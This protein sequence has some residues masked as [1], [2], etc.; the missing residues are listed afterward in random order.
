MSNGATALTK[1]KSADRRNEPGIAPKHRKE[2]P[3]SWAQLAGAGLNF[4]G[5]LGTAKSKKALGDFRSHAQWMRTNSEKDALRDF[6]YQQHFARNSAGW[7]MDDLFAAADRSGIHRLAALGGSGAG[8]TP[9]GSSG[10][11]GSPPVSNDPHL[12]DAIGTALDSINNAKL[13]KKK[14]E[15]T[16][17]QLDLEEKRI[18]NEMQVARSRTAIS[19]ARAREDIESTNTEAFKETDHG[20]S[21]TRDV[22]FAPEEIAMAKLQKG[23]FVP[24]FLHLVYNNTFAMSKREGEALA[25][26]VQKLWSQGKTKEVQSII[27]NVPKTHPLKRK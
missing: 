26:R 17:R 3:M 25:E 1:P 18:D 6:N 14:L 10:G 12:G 2:Q 13:A 22:N 24:W 15:Q 23:N 7:R 11:G 27:K 20:D 16:D 19:A 5:G 4:L 8:Y 21:L 9:A